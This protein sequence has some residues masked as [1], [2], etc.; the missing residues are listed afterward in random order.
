MGKA[1]SFSLFFLKAEEQRQNKN[2]LGDTGKGEKKM[3]KIYRCDGTDLD[4]G[5]AV[6]RVRS[7]EVFPVRH[8]GS[9]QDSRDV[10]VGRHGRGR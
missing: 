2:M 3:G 6:T 9:I 5:V 10:A 7:E 8:V 4:N 1:L